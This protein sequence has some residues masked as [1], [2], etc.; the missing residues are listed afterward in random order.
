MEKVYLLI[1]DDEYP[2]EM[3]DC[4]Q[5]INVSK[6]KFFKPNGP[7]YNLKWTYMTLMRAALPKI[8]PD[9]DI[10]LSLDN[11]VIV[12]RNINDIWNLPISQ[13]YYSAAREPLKSYGG[14]DYKFPLYTQMGVVLFNLKK[15]RDTGMVNRVIDAL[16]AYWFSLVEQD[17]MNLL[18]QGYI[19]P[20]PAE[21]NA[22][23]YTEHVDNPKMVHF[24]AIKDWT[25]LPLVE[26]YRN[27][28][29]SEIRKGEQHGTGNN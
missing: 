15:L 29:W 8:F 19:F 3:P 22:T 23:N 5:A 18:C 21:Y 26:K 9:L 6:Q 28:P 2:F 1:E 17:C 27:I 12:D 13:F 25:H 20:M 16:N 10:I 11:D 14:K 24:A 7:N 4:V